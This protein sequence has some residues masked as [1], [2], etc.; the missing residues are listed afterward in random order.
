MDLHIID[1]ESQQHF[2]STTPSLMSLAGLSRADQQK[3]DEERFREMGLSDPP[4]DGLAIDV[5]D[6]DDGSVEEE[7]GSIAEEDGSDVED[8]SEDEYKEATEVLPE[9]RVERYDE[10]YAL[11]SD[12]DR[13]EPADS[14]DGSEADKEDI[15][16]ESGEGPYAGEEDPGQVYK[17]SAK[18]RIEA[19]IHIREDLATFLQEKSPPKDA[20][21]ATKLSRPSTPYNYSYSSDDED[22][23]KPSDPTDYFESGSDVSPKKGLSGYLN[24]P[25]PRLPFL[26]RKSSLRKASLPLQDHKP[27]FSDMSQAQSNSSSPEIS[28]SISVRAEQGSPSPKFSIGQ[29][30]THSGNARLV[31]TPPQSKRDSSDSRG[32]IRSNSPATVSPEP[33]SK[34][35]SQTVIDLTQT[36]PSKQQIEDAAHYLTPEEQSTIGIAISPP[37]PYAN[38]NNDGTTNQFTPLPPPLFLNRHTT[39]PQKKAPRIPSSDTDQLQQARGTTLSPI[40]EYSTPIGTPETANQRSTSALDSLFN[41]S[42]ASIRERRFALLNK[43]PSQL[44]IIIPTPEMAL[45]R[46]R[47]ETEDERR[48]AAE[49]LEEGNGDSEVEEEGYDSSRQPRRRPKYDNLKEMPRDRE[50]DGEEGVLEGE[51]LC[52]TRE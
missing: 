29:I 10:D 36:P 21:N 3:L 41:P 47:S 25:L 12:V 40:S 42:T 17:D 48:L 30:V 38:H 7:E 34:L 28:P 33:T 8:I 46:Q 4:L 11:D 24:R 16:G 39:D 49:I 5:P 45:D 43:V 32:T 20:I 15:G 6:E 31:Y 2:I 14:I 18:V 51:W 27:S 44:S 1:P 13:L 23:E 9:L 19:A 22:A 50:M 26:P 37:S 35:D 52:G